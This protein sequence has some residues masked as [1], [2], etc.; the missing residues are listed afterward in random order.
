MVLFAESKNLLTVQVILP[1]APDQS[2]FKGNLPFI[3]PANFAQFGKASKKLGAAVLKP[4]ARSSY[5]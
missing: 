1:M 3:P 2:F 4:L 5:D